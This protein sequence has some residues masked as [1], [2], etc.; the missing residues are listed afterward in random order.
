MAEKSTWIDCSRRFKALA[1]FIR[2]ADVL[3]RRFNLTRYFLPYWCARCKWTRPTGT[4]ERRKSIEAPLN[5]MKVKKIKEGK[6]PQTDRGG[7]V[8]G[9]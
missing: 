2:C 8:W 3:N 7:K 6:D 4:A 5:T 1:A 9:Q